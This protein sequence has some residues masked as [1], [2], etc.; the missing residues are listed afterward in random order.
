MRFLH[1]CLRKHMYRPIVK[2]HKIQKKRIFS[3]FFSCSK[4]TLTWFKSIFCSQAEINS[5][6]LKI[7]SNTFGQSLGHSYF[8]QHYRPERAI[9]WSFCENVCPLGDH[10]FSVFARKNIGTKF[11]DSLK[12][13]SFRGYTDSTMFGV[14]LKVNCIRIYSIN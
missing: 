3:S 12:E 2:L 5:L 11:G 10:S 14:F 6:L 9:F 4:F 8:L 7:R 13:K 1:R